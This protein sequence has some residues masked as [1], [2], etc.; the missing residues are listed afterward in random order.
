[1]ELDKRKSLLIFPE[2]ESSGSGENIKLAPVRDSGQSRN[3]EISR[4]KGVVSGSK[5]ISMD[6]FRADSLTSEEEI[7]ENKLLHI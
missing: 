7:K 2:E 4:D 1:M 5:R 6:T 3:F